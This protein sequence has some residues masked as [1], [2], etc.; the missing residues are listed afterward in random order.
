MYSNNCLHFLKPAVSLRVHQLH[1]MISFLNFHWSEVIEHTFCQTFNNLI[2][3]D[4]DCVVGNCECWLNRKILVIDETKQNEILLKSK[5]KDWEN[6]HQILWTFV[7]VLDEIWPIFFHFSLH[8]KVS[9]IH[10]VNN[11]FSSHLSNILHKSLRIL[12]N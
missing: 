7:K 1:S 6:F 2:C 8:K 12:Q 3:T 10:P 9:K 4:N 5:M 11:K